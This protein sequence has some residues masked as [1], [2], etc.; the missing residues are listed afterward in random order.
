VDFDQ[1]EILAGEAGRAEVTPRRGS[2]RRSVRKRNR[3]RIAAHA[4]RLRR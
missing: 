2:R 4:M 3:P 1:S